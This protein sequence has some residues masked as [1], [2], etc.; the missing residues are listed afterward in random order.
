MITS[1]KADVPELDGTIIREGREPME[2]Q[3]SAAQSGKW[4]LG[5]PHLFLV[6]LN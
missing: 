1:G 6:S 2:M 3:M 5:L 4:V